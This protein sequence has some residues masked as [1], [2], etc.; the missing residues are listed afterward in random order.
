[1]GTCGDVRMQKFCGRWWNGCQDAG[2][3]WEVMEWMSGCR[4]SVGGGGMDVRMQKF[5]GR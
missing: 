3:L 5:C 1:M 2:V 4:S